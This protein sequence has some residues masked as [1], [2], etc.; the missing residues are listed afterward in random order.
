[1]FRLS[2]A[3]KG[4]IALWPVTCRPG[5]LGVWDQSEEWW[6]QKGVCFLAKDSIFFSV[7]L[8]ELSRTACAVSY[9]AT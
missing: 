1:M 7:L 4:S 2:R 3:W 6:G 9:A 8:K 5:F